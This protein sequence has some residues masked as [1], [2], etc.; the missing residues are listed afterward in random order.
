MASLSRMASARLLLAALALGAAPADRAQVGGF[1][2]TPAQLAEYYAVYTNGDVKHLRVV[3]ERAGA[4]K[5]DGETALVRGFQGYLPRKFIVL[6]REPLL[7]GGAQLSIMFQGKADAI[8]FAW[9]YDRGGRG[10]DR[11]EL[12]GFKKA[13]V[14]AERV[15]QAAERYR[16]F[17]EDAEH[18]M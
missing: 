7:V 1:D 12:R 2:P 5:A 11:Y 4:G 13:D 14:P 6:A 15:E 3:F 18:A 9:V 16:R 17:L 8:F 10:P